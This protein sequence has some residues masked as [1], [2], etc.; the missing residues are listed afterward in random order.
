MIE[1]QQAVVKMSKSK[2]MISHHQ[3]NID[4]F[5]PDIRINESP[6]E[7]VTDFKFL[8]L[9]IDQYLNLNA[10]IQNRPNKISRTLGVMNRLKR[11]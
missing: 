5:I 2:Y 1:Y 7:R 8:G 3:R 11:Y 9:Q 4:K 10:H 6:T